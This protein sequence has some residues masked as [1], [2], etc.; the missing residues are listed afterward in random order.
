[1]PFGIQVAGPCGADA[2]VL[3]VAHAIERHLARNPATARPLPD[4]ARLR[5]AAG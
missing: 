1:M 4:L 5:R 2:T 3:E